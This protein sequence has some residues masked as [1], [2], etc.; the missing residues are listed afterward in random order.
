M[1]HFTWRPL[2]LCNGR[3]TAKSTHEKKKDQMSLD[4]KHEAAA[5]ATAARLLCALKAQL[6]NS[7]PNEVGVI[8]WLKPLPWKMQT[9]KV[10]SIVFCPT[11]MKTST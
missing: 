8:T 2:T 7:T 11:V 3:L 6:E 4:D 5:R 9:V 1:V 10:G